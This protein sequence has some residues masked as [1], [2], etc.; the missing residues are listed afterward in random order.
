MSVDL[1]P[2]WQIGD[3]LLTSYPYGVDADSTVD[4]GEPE[5]VVET[6]TSQSA[7]GDHQRVLRHGNRTYVLEVYAEGATLADL[8]SHEAA[9]RSELHRTGLLLTHTPGDGLTPASVYEVQIAQLTPE[10][11]DRHES[12]LIRKFT[13]TL[14]CAPFARSVDLTTVPALVIEPDAAPDV[15][16]DAA[17]STTGWTT[18][19]GYS[20][21]VAADTLRTTSPASPPAGNVVVELARGPVDMSA[22]AYLSAIWQAYIGESSANPGVATAQLWA[23][24]VQVAEEARI[25]VE[26]PGTTGAWYQ[27]WYAPASISGGMALRLPVTYSASV[28]Y[29]TLAV[30]EI[31]KTNQWPGVS[32]RQ[33]TRVVEVGGTERTPASLHA[34][35]DSGFLGRAVVHTTPAD[36]SGYTPD[37]TRWNFS[38]SATTPNTD[39]QF[40]TGL[41]EALQPSSLIARRPADSV[42]RGDYILMAAIRSTATG[43][44]AISY[45]VK[46]ILEDG[47][48]IGNVTGTAYYNFEVANRM[49]FVPI[50]AVSAPIVRSDRRLDL[51]VHL[52]NPLPGA[53]SLFV[54]EWWLFS[55]GPDSALSIVGTDEA[56]LWLESADAASPVPRVW[57][58]NANGRFHPNTRLIAQGT[59]T[60]TPGQMRVT[61]IS[62]ANNHVEV[63][64]S[65]FKRWHSNAAE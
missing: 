11:N 62:D 27:S 36:D 13:L 64:L 1:V 34:F 17:N 57:V 18:N 33:S 4:I 32:A 12:H 2:E 52:S 10:R 47:T 38:G 25:R 30:A 8:A 21:A 28:R 7:D 42:P 15:L 65:Y 43:E 35:T 53:T 19:P 48:V 58:G 44:R 39:P 60:F 14:T 29:A 61:T 37:L 54:E 26:V 50:A 59:H 40:I 55:D 16:V 41:W 31:K 46:S 6:V 49:E 45:A 51:E 24:G 9:L 56:E 22:H 23:D 3:L 20:L 63:D 5:M